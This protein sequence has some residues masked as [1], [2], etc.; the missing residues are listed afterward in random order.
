MTVLVTIPARRGKAAH[1]RQGQVVK[2]INTHGDQVVDTWAFNA[3]DLTEFMSMEHTRPHIL[4]IIP[5][6]GDAMMTNRRRPIL[7]L[8]EDTSGGIHDTIIAACDSHRYR[9]LGVEG[10]HDNCTDNL[11]AAMRD[12]GLEAPETPSPLNLFMNIPVRP[13]HSLSFEP[14]VS[15][16][17]SHVALRAE[18]D[19]VIAF[20]AC[21]QDILPI[22]GVG[23]MPTEAHFSL[24]G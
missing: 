8:L 17:G 13:D 2:V 22:N 6:V 11:H 4:K 3:H 19:L 15:T 12:L 18:M 16:P 21:P 20:S 5:A 14:P 10:Y 24:E 1:V 7:T 23:H 9:F